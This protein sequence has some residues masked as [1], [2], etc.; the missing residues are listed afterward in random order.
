MEKKKMTTT[1]NAVLTLAKTI[2]N[3]AT[4][5]QEK[6][7]KDGDFL[8]AS[9]QLVHNTIT[10]VF[11]LGEHYASQKTATAP[12]TKSVKSVKSVKAT[13]VSNPN[14]T[15]LTPRWHN[16]RDSKGRFAPKAV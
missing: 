12:T 13:A 10:L 7:E 8:A 14:G 3:L 9:N 6:L 5:V 11:A 1:Q 16:V 15:A 2:G 4:E